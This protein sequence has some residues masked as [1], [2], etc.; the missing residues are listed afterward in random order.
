MHVVPSVAS[1][2]A[3]MTSQAA[4]ALKPPLPPAGSAI[5]LQSGLPQPC[6]RSGAGRGGGVGWGGVGGGGAGGLANGKG[7]HLTRGGHWARQQHVGCLLQLPLSVLAPPLAAAARLPGSTGSCPSGTRHGPSNA[8]AQRSRRR[9]AAAQ[10]PGTAHSTAGGGHEGAG[11]RWGQDE[12]ATAVQEHGPKG[13]RQRWQKGGN[14]GECGARPR[15]SYPAGPPRQFP[16]WPRRRRS[17]AVAP[18][19]A[20]CRSG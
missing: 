16:P 2:P 13:Q 6:S 17:P 10:G 11:G 19:A 20:G 12:T 5:W 9:P 4:Q 3:V 7:V 1:R 18:P 15:C 8:P 14:P